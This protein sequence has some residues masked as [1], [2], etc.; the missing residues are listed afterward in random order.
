MK[1]FI[2]SILILVTCITLAVYGVKYWQVASES[3]TPPIIIQNTLTGILEP[4]PS[5]GEFSDT[6]TENGKTVGV[7]SN[8]INLIPYEN[9]KVMVIGE[10]S[11]NTMYIDSITIL[12]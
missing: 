3:G 7:T 5:T 11:G 4:I 12:Q 2:L 9:K 1:A 8:K 10:Y 6:I